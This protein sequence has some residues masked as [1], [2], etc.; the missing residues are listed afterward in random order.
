MAPTAKKK[1]TPAS[2]FT[3]DHVAA[4]GQHGEAQEDG[5]RPGRSGREKMHD[6]VG[7]AG[8]DVFL[9]QRLHAVGDGLQDAEG[10]DAVGAVAVLDAAQAF[11]F[12]HGG[13][14]EESGNQMND[15]RRRRSARRQ[16]AAPVRAH[17]QRASA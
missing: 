13:D 7:R 12:K 6:L 11:A 1:S 9:G 4:H 10:A 8:N 5:Q 2:R 17:A 15:R 16:R 3:S 14:G